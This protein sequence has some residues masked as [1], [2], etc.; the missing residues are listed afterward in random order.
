MKKN[1]LLKK[2]EGVQTVETVMSTLGVSREKA[3]Y[4]VHRLN[5]EGYVKKR[6][7]PSKKR[8]YFISR[9]NRLGGTGYYE[10]INKDSPV[11]LSLAETSRIYGREVAPEEALVFAITTKKARVVL[12]SLSLFRRI[13]DWK[14]FYRLA[15]EKGVV[16]KAGALYDLSRKFMRTRRMDGRLRRMMLPKKGDGFEYIVDG[17]R[18]TDA[19]FG[20]IQDLWRV[21]IPFSRGDMED[22]L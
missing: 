17:L 21:Y 5:K 7:A 10:I 11:K 16:R 8:V 4:S 12:A 14:L 6:R 19:E 13:S 9:E 18:T 3:I 22:Y 20:K 15:K 2:L 1:D